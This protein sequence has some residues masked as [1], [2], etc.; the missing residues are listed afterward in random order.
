MI[1]SSSWHKIHN[2]GPSSFLPNAVLFRCLRKIEIMLQFHGGFNGGSSKF[3][4]MLYL[5]HDQNRH[6]VSFFSI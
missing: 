3:Y 2:I 5:N 4:V 6:L 1:G